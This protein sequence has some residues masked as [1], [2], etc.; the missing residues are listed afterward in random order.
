MRIVEF[1]PFGILIGVLARMLANGEGRRRWPT[2]MLAG[3]GGAL[4]GGLVGRYFSL[5]RDEAPRGFAMSLLG[6]FV[7][8][9]LF[10]VFSSSRVRA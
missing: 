8:V 5:S 9:A 1:V 10:H 2:S 4:L 6:A 7:F 3:G